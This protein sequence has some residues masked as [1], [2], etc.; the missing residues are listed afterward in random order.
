MN[1][2]LIIADDFTGANDSGVQLKR[3]GIKTDVVFS[4]KMM[5]SDS[6]SYVIDTES[7]GLSSDEA[8]QYL[9]NFAS[10][11]RTDEFKYIIKKVDS[12]LRGNIAEEVK[13]LDQVFNSDL[14]IFMPALPDLNR[15]TVNGIH[16]LNN[17]PI[18]ETEIA[19]D[20]KKPV[21]ED[22][23]SKILSKRF[24][25]NINHIS[26]DHIESNNLELRGGRVFSCDS[27]TN[28]HMK[29]VIKKAIE[30]KKKVLWVGTA[31]IVENLMEV[32]KKTKPSMAMIGSVSS[33]T[34]NQVKYAEE[35][36]ITLL[37][38]PIYEILEGRDAEEYVG[39]AIEALQA[40]KDLLVLSSSS[41][42]EEEYDKTNE[43]GYRKNMTNEEISVFT[44]G[45][46][47]DISKEIISRVEVSGVFLT[48][49]DTARGFFEKT[50]AL[51]STIVGEVMIGIPM[52]KLRGGEFEGLNIITKAGAFGN[53]DTIY[54][55]M[56]KLKEEIN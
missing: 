30:S 15:T 40:G 10:E 35:K 51:G 12:T 6:T 21:T 45:V 19:R 49:G 31:A 39:K 55:S 25:E 26:I 42:C 2:Y 23:L 44:Q 50:G 11:V 3:R 28:E 33:V 32:E 38:I 29:A 1:R 48:G 43:V 53:I 18:T 17:V 13:A 4:T 47:G 7:R 5:K 8:Y 16:M 20:P 24:N 9:Y 36:G 22:N 41:Y 56:R 34:R 14:I 46:L 52:M 37:K 27:L 54:Y